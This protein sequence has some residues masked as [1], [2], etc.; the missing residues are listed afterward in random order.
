MFSLAQNIRSLASPLCRRRRRGAPETTYR[1][2]FDQLFEP[3]DDFDEWVLCW[4]LAQQQLKTWRD[5][6]LRLDVDDASLDERDSER[7]RHMHFEMTAALLREVLRLIFTRNTYAKQLSIGPKKEVA[8]L[9]KRLDDLEGLVSRQL[10]DKSATD[11]LRAHRNNVFHIPIVFKTGVPE[12]EFKE[13]VERL[14][15]EGDGTQELR[16]AGKV[17][18]TELT[19][20]RHLQGSMLA[21]A[22]GV[23]KKDPEA[24]ILTERLR[25]LVEISHQL[26]GE[27]DSIANLL[28]SLQLERKG[29]IPE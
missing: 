1:F 8:E 14:A 10:G 29:F 5:V 24:R 27:L 2:M 19:F 26:T 9:A 23:P 6:F 4:C 25:G 3:G 12:R 21:F 16:S 22:L 11:V 13:A 28:V 7:F 20:V 17:G 18:N 15:S